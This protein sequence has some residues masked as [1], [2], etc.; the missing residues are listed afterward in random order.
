MN[1][2]CSRAL[3]L[4]GALEAKY[5]KS[6][7][8][9]CLE[10]ICSELRMSPDSHIMRVPRSLVNDNKSMERNQKKDTSLNHWLR[11]SGR[12]S[13]FDHLE[14]DFAKIPNARM[15]QERAVD[16]LQTFEK[17]HQSLLKSCFLMKSF[18]DEKMKNRLEEAK[19]DAKALLA[20][21]AGPSSAG[22]TNFSF[23]LVPLSTNASK[24]ALMPLDCDIGLSGCLFPLIIQDRASQ[25]IGAL[26]RSWLAR[27]K[28]K[29]M[30]LSTDRFLGLVKIQDLKEFAVKSP[31][32]VTEET[33][34]NECTLLTQRR[35]EQDVAKH[36][37]HLLNELRTV[38]GEILFDRA[39]ALRRKWILSYWRAKGKLPVSMDLF[40][41]ADIER[42]E[43][44]L[45]TLAEEDV[46]KQE[47]NAEKDKQKKDNTKNIASKVPGPVILPDGRVLPGSIPSDLAPSFGVHCLL[48]SALDEWSKLWRGLDDF[49]VN[50][51]QT[52][53]LQV[54]RYFAKR[55]L[56]HEISL[57]AQSFIEDELS[58]LHEM[59]TGDEGSSAASKKSSKA[60]KSSSKSSSKKAKIKKCCSGQS[61][62]PPNPDEALA[63]LV[64]DG[65]CI[66]FAPA[67]L[68]SDFIPPRSGM[69]SS[70]ATDPGLPDIPGS[71]SF[72]GA[73][74]PAASLL[75][76]ITDQ[77]LMPLSSVEIRKESPFACRSALLYGPPGCGKSLIA[78][79]IAA[80]V[81]ALFIDL[82]PSKISGKYVEKGRAGAAELVHRAFTVA[83]SFAPAVIY[84]D[85]AEMIFANASARK[86]AG[87]KENCPSRI[88]K[89]LLSHLKKI[90]PSS[91]NCSEGD[92][93]IFIGAAR[94][95][96]A[97]T[98]TKDMNA[99]FELML[100][101]P[102]PDSLARA[103]LWKR[104]LC[105][106]A[107]KAWN[108]ALASHSNIPG[109]LTDHTVLPP[110][111]SV[112]RHVG[113]G[114]YEETL[115]ALC[116]VSEGYS[117]SSIFDAVKKVCTVS[118][119]RRLM[120][121]DKRNRQMSLQNQ[122]NGESGEDDQ[123]EVLVRVQADVPDGFEFKAREF[124]AALANMKSWTPEEQ[125][126]FI[127]PSYVIA[128]SKK[129]K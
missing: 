43:M 2:I 108:A 48:E 103:Q 42:L 20:S 117:A 39:I 79:A 33:R 15:T 83:Q 9:I 51:D 97:E 85:Q 36:A 91:P 116:R 94:Q 23:S 112:E 74:P 29:R 56:E 70:N 107:S 34:I 32:I 101:V 68:Y 80:S 76:V 88:K 87:L 26:V 64:M 102:L 1:C 21:P 78:R 92:R 109:M 129:G 47:Q 62:C 7:V 18:K 115:A 113:G 6:K 8:P 77:I 38:E 54:G 12:S 86:K 17:G 69:S 30:K 71:K 124:A 37:D 127:D 57:K 35:H 95:A 98:E 58:N 82:S 55:V 40:D 60:S 61:A 100:P 105:M 123:H 25:R 41:E 96:F 3:Q 4:R 45:P 111:F 72:L 52:F 11:S 53:D 5:D 16:I 49:S 89:E 110:G 24:T 104:A 44:K 66:K 19:L 122:M 73:R 128:K 81:N 65:L 10:Q 93:V 50:F 13:Q 46:L 118:R 28:V 84:F 106:T 14:S 120:E 75:R 126:V 114:L 119:L 99:F 59:Y 22:A 90:N 125:R 67:D 27:I 31:S 121:G 63:D